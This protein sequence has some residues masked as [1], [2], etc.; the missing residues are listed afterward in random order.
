MNKEL[1]PTI[2]TETDD[3]V[4]IAKPSG[5][6]THPSGKTKEYSVSQWFGELYPDSLEVGEPLLTSIGGEIVEISRPGIVHRLDKDTSG[7]MVLA[8]N[9]EFFEL[10]KNQFGQRKVK[11]TYLAIV[12][13]IMKQERGTINEPIG[14]ERG[15][16]ERMATGSRIRGTSR[17][18]E[19]TYMVMKTGHFDGKKFSLLQC[20][21]K[22]GRTHQIRVHLAYAK[23]PILSDVLYGPKNG[24]AEDVGICNRMALH[25]WR[26]AF[27]D[28][29]GMERSFTMPP[30]EDFLKALAALDIHG[31][32]W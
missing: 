9:Q 18:A 22:T 14:R 13:G 6:V 26:L 30:G 10:L 11:K 21:P 16:I 27:F 2:I 32:L 7:V 28:K 29:Q 20:I 25:A 12:H 24:L 3:Y 31:L 15:G 4:V 23:H 19:T 17:P 8:K 5:L 1:K